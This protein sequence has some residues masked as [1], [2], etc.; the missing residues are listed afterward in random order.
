MDANAIQD[1]QQQNQVLQQ[2]LN[3][4]QATLQAVQAQQAAQQPPPPPQQNIVFAREPAQANQAGLLN[5]NDRN[6]IELHKNGSKALPGDPYDGTKIQVWLGKVETRGISLGMQNILTFNGELIT[7]RYA[8]INRQDVTNTAIAYQVAQGRDAQNASILFNCLSASIND[9]IRTKVNTEPDRYVLQLPSAV[10]GQTIPVNDGTCFLKA[11]IDHT[12]THTL[13]NASMAREELSSLDTYMKTIKKSNI[14]KF[15]L[16]VK[17]KIKELE[18]ANEITTDLIV[19]LFKGYKKAND[20]PFKDWVKRLQEDYNDR[21]ATFNPN[22]LDLM[23]K[24]E[25]YYKDKVRANEWG[26]L[27]EDQQTILALK[28]QLQQNKDSK[29]K[30]KGE[31]DKDKESKKRGRDK[32]NKENEPYEKP[33]WKLQAPKDSEPK[34]KDV[35][36][37]TYHWCTGHKEWTIHTSASCRLNSA[38]K[39]EKKQKGDKKKDKEGSGDGKDKNPKKKKNLKLKVMEAIAEHADSDSEGSYYSS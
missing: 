34:K 19:N 11:I 18:A 32:E 36:G 29:K 9:E 12:Y 16:Y 2:Q 5:Y 3:Q 22:G 21:K 27:D 7:R 10:P 20:K 39:E 17:E 8:D 35:E 38:E 30:K 24:V 25:T 4:L 13:S 6:D 31:K 26:K 14:T 15:N 33:A 1:L 28:A 23:E 37:K